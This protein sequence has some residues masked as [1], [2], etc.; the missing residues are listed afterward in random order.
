M[1]SRKGIT[2]ARV[3][4]ETERTILNMTDA[5]KVRDRF[6]DRI[7]VLVYPANSSVPKIDKSKYLVPVDLTFGQFIFVVRKRLKMGPEEAL[8]L[9]TENNTIPISSSLMLN[10]DDKNRNRKGYLVLYYSSENTFG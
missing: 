7:P 1:L 4:R 3:R 10:I 9:F 2:D 5:W 6:F 8:F